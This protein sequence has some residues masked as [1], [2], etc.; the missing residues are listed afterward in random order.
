MEKA[1]FVAVVCFG[2]EEARDSILDYIFT[3]VEA[4]A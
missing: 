4:A 2:W 1:G 3:K